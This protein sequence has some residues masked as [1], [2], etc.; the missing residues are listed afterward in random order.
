MTPRQIEILFDED[1]TA[2]EPGEE[3]SGQ[4]LVVPNDGQTLKAVEVSVLWQ[5]EGKGDEDL[6]VTHF[7]RIEANTGTADLLRPINFRTRL[8]NSPLSYRGQILRII[9][10]VRVR[11]FPQRGNEIVAEERFQLGSVP[12]PSEDLATEPQA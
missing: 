8:P 5:T 4:F 10:C 11:A 12:S 1:R 7:E 6:G 2:F 9:W 3:L